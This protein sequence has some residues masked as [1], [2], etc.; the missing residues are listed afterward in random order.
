MGSQLPPCRRSMARSWLRS[1]IRKKM[2]LTV[3]I[4]RGSMLGPGLQSAHNHIYN[5]VGGA[6]QR[7]FMFAQ[8]PGC[9]H[10][11]ECAEE[12]VGGNFFGHFFAKNAGLLAVAHHA[13]DKIK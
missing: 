1:A 7:V 9:H 8:H 11:V 10:L 2:S 12:T 13:S 5:R 4:L 6:G 3:V